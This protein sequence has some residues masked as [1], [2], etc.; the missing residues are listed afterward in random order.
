MKYNS[1]NLGCLLILAMTFFACKEQDE[2]YRQ[3]VTEGGKVYPCK[4]ENAIANPGMGRVDISWPNTTRTVTAACIYWNNS[5]DSVWINISAQ[6]DTVRQSIELPEGIYSF[7]IKTF[8]KNGNVSVPVEVIGR[9][10]GDKYLSG[11]LNRLTANYKTKGGAQLSIDWEKADA[12][13]GALYCDVVYT[14]TDNSEKTLRVLAFEMITEITDHKPGTA[15]KYNTT[16]QPDPQDPLIVTTPY[17]DVTGIYMLL[18]NKGGEK[19][20]AYSSQWNADPGQRASNAYDGVTDHNRWHSAGGGYPHYITIDM[21][22]ETTVA[23]FGIWPSNQDN[24]FE[25]RMPSRIEWHVATGDIA[26]GNKDQSLFNTTGRGARQHSGKS[27]GMKFT[28]DREFASVMVESPTWSTANASLS[29]SIYEWNTNYATTI[30]STPVAT[31]RFEN[32]PDN[33]LLTVSGDAK[34]PAGTYLWLAHDGANTTG[35]WVGDAVANT[36]AFWDGQAESKSYESYVSYN[37]WTKLGEF[38]FIRYPALSYVYD[39]QLYDVAPVNARYVKLVG[40]DD[41][42]GSGIMCLAEIDVY[43]KLGD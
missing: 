25:D 15:L 1:I 22:A 7:I 28:V 29:L 39:V 2:M 33:S 12:S 10:I 3:Y 13:N 30:S 35:V 26:P 21:G 16:Y 32:Y 5:Q 9:S 14:A 8:D 20:I 41:P 24:H 36:E 31:K 6:T 38:G 18:D 43:S 34:I 17:K 37:S 40:L 4:A 27:C 23:R 19:V 11:F 42:G